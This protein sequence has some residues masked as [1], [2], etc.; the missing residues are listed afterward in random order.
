MPRKKVEATEQPSERVFLIDS[1]SHIFRAFFAPMGARMEPLTNSRGQVTQA[2]FVFTSMLRKLLADENPHYIAAVFE[3]ETPT[4]RHEMNVGYKAN[5]AEMPDELASQIPYIMRVCEVFNIPILNSPGF[6]ADDVIGALA[7]QVAEKGLQAVIVSNDKDMTQLVSDPLVVCMRQNSQNVKRKEPVPPVEWCDEAWVENKFG[8]PPRQIIDLLGLMGDAVDNIP[9]APG[10][11]AKGAVQIVKEFG[12]IENA[13]KNWEQVKHK[14]YRESLRNNADLILQSKELATIKTD[15]NIKLDLDKLRCQTPDRAAAYKLFREL[16]FQSLTR[17]FADAAGEGGGGPQSER[18]YTVIRKPEEL[19][20]LTRKLWDTEHWSFALAD[21]TPAGAGQQGSVR[22]EARPTGIAISTAAHTS[23][24]I[25][26]ENFDGG[27][28]AAL[29]HLRDVL[30]NGLLSKS[31]HDLKRAAALLAPLGITIEGLSDDTLLAAYLLDPVRSKYDLADLARDAVNSDGWSEETPEGWTESQWRTAEAADFTA[32]VADVLH[33]RILE[34]GLE[35]IYTD[36]ELPLAPLLYRMERAGLK[37][38]TDALGELSKLFGAE[39][40]KLTAQIYKEAGREFK[41][42]SPKQ[43][44]EVLESLNIS[45]GRKTSTGQVSTNRAVLDELAQQFELPRLIIEFRELDKLKATYTD[46]LPQQIGADGRI[47]SQLN[48]TVTATGRLSS[49]DPNLQNIPIRTE[50]GQRI[51]RAFVPEKGHVFIAA[52]YSQLEL[53]LL[54]HITRDERMLEAFQ[55]GDDIHA[56]TARLV[57]NAKT[58]AELKEKR[59]FAKI[60]NFAIAYAVEPFG[61][62]QR[63]GISRKEAKQVIDDYYKT[64]KGVREFMDKV[65][66]EAREHGLVRS[67]YGRIRPLPTIN[68][69]NGQIR[70]RAE[71]EAINMPIQGTASDIVKIAMLKVEDALRR[72]GLEAQMVMQVH[73]ELLIE[74]PKKEADRVASLLKHEMETAVELDVPLVAEVGVGANWMDVKK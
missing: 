34:Q 44:G 29:P 70:A 45:T 15:V 7:V 53:R 49:S 57:F 63:V 39:L 24:L 22:D 51:R 72:E 20:K 6:E 2:V 74:A 50:L 33:G 38:D 28:E 59:R 9:G 27:A 17:E 60:V 56:Q 14:T 3:S 32:Q 40:E 30:S 65:P 54:A 43:V 16:E 5:R 13:L 11:G 47:H 37:V 66:E 67:I 8:V 1:F 35:A 41:I 4:F 61:L 19:E 52:D 58:P 69:R 64:Y 68:D 62:S 71:R 55:N 12:S 42:N 26:L 18:R 10:I 73:D 46:S 21:S 25:D 23:S 48:Q 36:I 31:T